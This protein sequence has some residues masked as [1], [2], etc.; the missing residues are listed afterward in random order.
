MI[1]QAIFKPAYQPLFTHPGGGVRSNLGEPQPER[2]LTTGRSRDASSRDSRAFTHASGGAVGSE[3]AV[4]PTNRPDQQSP[5]D[6]LSCHP[7]AKCY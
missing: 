5:L 7:T 3:R 6:G 4:M 1:N 2:C